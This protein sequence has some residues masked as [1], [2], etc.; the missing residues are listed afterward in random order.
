MTEMPH[1]SSLVAEV[2]EILRRGIQLGEWTDPLPG[3]LAW[4]ER[5]KV[6]RTTLRAALDVL[7]R[8]GWIVASRG[9][10]MRLANRPPPIARMSKSRVVGLFSVQPTHML[11]SFS[12]FMISELQEG[13]H[14]DGYKLEVHA[15]ARFGLRNPS[16]SLTSLMSQT[17]ANCWVT[18]PPTDAC[19]RWFMDHRVRCLVLGS[20][21]WSYAFPSVDVD[22]RAAARHAVGTLRGRGCSS[23]ALIVADVKAIGQ[24]AIEQGFR[25]SL[26]GVETESQIIRV[27]DVVADIKARLDSLLA[28][29]NRP[30]ALLVA[31]PKHVLTVMSH[32]AVSG[33][34][35][36]RDVSVI[37]LGHDPYLD[38]LTPSIAHY[39]FSWKSF[40]RRVSVLVR[41]LADTGSLPC[42][43][44]LVMPQFRSAETLLS[45]TS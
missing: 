36:P 18:L 41:E 28:S 26:P 40:A 17:R 13:L 33:I 9:R 6:S 4:C 42:R 45:A 24:S 39:T 15:D 37:C 21:D 38:N 22:L 32:L 19:M 8:E 23:I 34:L 20:C 5:L 29:T 10:R 1:R 11:S 3:E 35:V 30:S 27:P 16:R 12:H 25:D 31:R 14:D 2:T 43:S 44:H 7:R